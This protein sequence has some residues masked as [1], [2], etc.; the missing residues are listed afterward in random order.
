[1]AENS[2]KSAC[3]VFG[4]ELESAKPLAP[5]KNAGVWRAIREDG[6]P[7]VV[8]LYDGGTFGYDANAPAMYRHWDGHGAVRLLSE[9]PGALCLEW[10]GDQS[11]AAHALAGQ[12]D[13]ATQVLAD[14]A[15]KLLAPRRVMPGVQLKTMIDRYDLLISGAFAG[16]KA[17]RPALSAARDFV[18][19]NGTPSPGHVPLHGDLH[20]R[21]IFNGPRGWLAIDPFGLIGPREAEFANTFRNPADLASRGRAEKMANVF[22]QRFALDRRALLGWGAAK[23]AHSAIW[24]HGFGDKSRAR[25]DLNLLPELLSAAGLTP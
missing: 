16:L 25:S 17:H 3:S 23:C 5:A 6:T 8:K 21:N 13:A 12:D 7:V 14:V 24:N 11:L 1:M 22:A 4:L 20:H 18:L 2:L 10:A 19:E 9:A 15:E